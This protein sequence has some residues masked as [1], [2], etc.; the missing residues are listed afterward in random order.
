MWGFFLVLQNVSQS[1]RPTWLYVVCE[2]CVWDGSGNFCRRQW[3]REEWEGRT[4]KLLLMV[5]MSHRYLVCG[6][7]VEAWQ[8]LHGVHVLDGFSLAALPPSGAG[9]SLQLCPSQAS[10]LLETAW[11]LPNLCVYRQCLV[12]SSKTSSVRDTNPKDSANDG[13]LAL[14][15]LHFC[16][17]KSVQVY[18]CTTSKCV[19]SLCD[20]Q[21]SELTGRF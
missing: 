13:K 10:F 9:W 4:A 1:P 12:S 14:K 17:Y 20:V 5:L 6:A 7:E 21:G 16:V 19:N 15:N 3:P 2:F 11:H 8:V 18:G